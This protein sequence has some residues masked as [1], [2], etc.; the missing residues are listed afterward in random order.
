MNYFKDKR[1]WIT[2][3]S[4]GIGRL[5]AEK[6]LAAGSRIV[7]TARREKLLNEIAELPEGPDRVAVVPG[8]VSR[9]DTV[10]ALCAEAWRAFGGLDIVI[11][12]AGV[13][14]RSLFK[15]T[16]FT[17]G[18][19]LFDINFF[20]HAK[21]IHEIL[22]L[23]ERQGK[24]HIVGISSLSGLIASPLRI[25]YS[26]AKHALHGF[27]DT[28]RTELY[29]T[30]INISLVVPGFIRTDISRSA[31]NGTGEPFGRNDSLQKNGAS[32]EKAADKILRQIA[33]KK[34]E[35]YVGY[36]LNARIA[37]FLGK[38]FPGILARILSSM[39]EVKE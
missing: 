39:T 2:G 26:S 35:I 38:F 6:L 37:R 25:Y 1:I 24:G 17:T 7:V 15:D 3:A 12:N 22:P 14:Q 10:S 9:F 4:S 27:Y 5:M 34:R 30:D 32:P 33:A 11:L 8:D 19:R 36:P 16:D 13:S 29:N 28:L 20:S 18:C 31:L 23:M 21:I